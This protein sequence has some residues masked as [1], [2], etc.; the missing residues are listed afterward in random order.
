[1][2]DDLLGVFLERGVEHRV[3]LQGL[4]HSLGEEG[5]E[6]E[7]GALALLELVQKHIRQRDLSHILQQLVEVVL[8]GYTDHQQ[9]KTLFTY[10]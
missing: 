2:V 6:R 10:M 5:H 8:M 9:F 1:V 7:L 3:S 4:G